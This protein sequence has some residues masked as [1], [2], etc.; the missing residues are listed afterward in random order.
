MQASRLHVEWLTLFKTVIHGFA[1][2]CPVAR[3]FFVVNK[4]PY[5]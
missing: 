4:S 3:G 2:G 1:L 5:T